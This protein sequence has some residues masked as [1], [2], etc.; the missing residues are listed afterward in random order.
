MLQ[1]QNLTVG[2]RISSKQN[3]PVLDVRNLK[4]HKGELVALIGANGSGKSTLLRSIAGLQPLLSGHIL[5]DNRPSPNFHP[6]ERARLLSFVST[7]N[8]TINN[9]KVKDLI[10]FGRAPHTNW[11][12]RLRT[13]DRYYIDKALELVGMT[14]FATKYIDQLSDGERQRIMLARSLAQNAGLIILDEP[15]AFLD[16]QN[17]YI[18]VDLLRK[19]CDNEQK[20]ILFSTHDLNIALRFADKIWLTSQKHITEG[21][22]EDL[23]LNNAFQQIFNSDK[24]KFQPATGDFEIERPLQS[25][26]FFETGNSLADFWTQKALKRL[27]YKMICDRNYPLKLQLNENNNRKEWLLHYKNQNTVHYSIYSLTRH[28][29]HLKKQK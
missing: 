6:T 27:G 12:G 9:L 21:A 13:A 20:T 4:V 11:L 23:I 18:I 3:I 7:E 17:K 1:L 22:A 5:L 28:L 15:T 14:S 19:L 25:A 24:L 10:A 16:L 26:I 2:Y 29:R 8:I